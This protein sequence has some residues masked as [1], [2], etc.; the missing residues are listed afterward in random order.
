M[1][2]G[3]DTPFSKNSSEQWP[4]ARSHTKNDH[5]TTSATTT[6]R[7]AQSHNDRGT[8]KQSAWDRAGHESEIPITEKLDAVKAGPIRC[9]DSTM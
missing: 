5:K 2:I 3:D 8:L 9:V 6:L 1:H 4:S 7:T